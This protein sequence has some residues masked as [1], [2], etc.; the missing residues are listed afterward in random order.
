MSELASQD[1][2][3]LDYLMDANCTS[4]GWQSLLDKFLDHFNLRHINLYMVDSKFNVLFQEWSGAQPTVQAI[5]HYMD[6]IFPH[7]KV[8]Q[9][10]LMSPECHWVTG[11]FEPYQTMLNEMPGFHDWA[12]DYNFP[13]TTGCVLY[14]S[15]QGQVQVTFQRGFEHGPFTLE[16]EERFT[17]MSRYLS[18]AIELRI[19]IA[20][21]DKNDLRLKSILNKMRLPVSAVNEFGDIVAHN[22]SMIGF[23][24]SQSL[25]KIDDNQ[26]KLIHD[27]ANQML[28]HA[29]VK[30][31]ANSKNLESSFDSDSSMIKVSGEEVEFIVGACELSEGADDDSFS[32]ALLY[33]VSPEFCKSIKADQLKSLFGLTEAE[34]QVC[35]AFANNMTLKEIAVQEGK[36]VNTVRE[37]LQ[38]CYAKTN[39][40]SQLELIN[41]LAS[42]PVEG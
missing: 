37:Q 24:Q 2:L 3:L 6:D 26:L 27:D 42:L 23:L 20:D 1:I 7:D 12:K 28:K 40:K 14:R 15:P 41:L 34:A 5:K 21:Q 39:T 22:D 36:S 35:S 9:T 29:I 4:T 32:G 18:K 38:N 30:S 31:V 8:H 11:N 17:Q 13:Y 16:E 10:M 19:R 25:L 33:V